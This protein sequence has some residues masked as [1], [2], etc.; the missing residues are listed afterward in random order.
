MRNNPYKNYYAKVYIREPTSSKWVWVNRPIVLG[1]RFFGNI[2]SNLMRKTKRKIYARILPEF[3][4]S[5]RLAQCHKWQIRKNLSLCVDPMLETA[6]Q[7]LS[8]MYCIKIIPVAYICVIDGYIY[9]LSIWSVF[10]L[11]HGVPVTC[12]IVW[13]PF[14]YY[15]ASS[16]ELFG[17]SLSFVFELWSYLSV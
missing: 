11:L 12:Y 10:Y 1:K 13:N 9:L 2:L 14:Y 8:K 7:L 17:Y 4:M 3:Y 16:T 6:C 5:N 15:A